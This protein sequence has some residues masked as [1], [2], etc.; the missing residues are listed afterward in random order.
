MQPYKWEIIEIMIRIVKLIPVCLSFLLAL[1]A[2][3]KG[4]K[5]VVKGVVTDADGQMMYLENRKV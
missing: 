3:N 5:F 1:A 2:C 4:D